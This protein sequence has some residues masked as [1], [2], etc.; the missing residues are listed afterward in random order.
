MMQPLVIQRI[1]QRALNM[2]LP[3]QLLEILRTPLARQYLIAHAEQLIDV[4]N[5]PDHTPDH[6]H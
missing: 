3:N 5:Q 2:F 6:H 4:S 1:Y